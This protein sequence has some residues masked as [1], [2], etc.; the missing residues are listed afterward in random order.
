[1]PRGRTRRQ[2]CRSSQQIPARW[3]DLHLH[4]T[5]S[6]GVYAPAKLIE[7]AATRGLSAV[8][9]TDHDTTAGLPEAAAAARVHGIEFVPGIELSARYGARLIHILGYW[10]NPESL[11]LV[12][13]LADQAARGAQRM[14]RIRSRLRDCGISIEDHDLADAAGSRVGR[15]HVA[16]ILVR[17]GLVRDHDEAFT[18]YLGVGA[19][20]F[21][22][23]EA[24]PA[25]EAI[26]AIRAAGGVACLAHPVW[27]G[28]TSILELETVIRDLMT[29]GLRGLEV[30][31][32]AQSGEWAERCRALAE[33]LG[34]AM[35]GGTDF[36]GFGGCAQR[37]VGFGNPRVAY[38]Y[39]E[40]LNRCRSAAT[41]SP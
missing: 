38:E 19:P 3:V 9:L 21:V 10:I 28:C 12:R 37:G 20:A 41:A 24:L 35:T 26:E 7:L 34:L 18:K 32:P 1:M 40:A 15:P 2:L 31:H 29:A 13:V 30:L 25:A 22:E 16:R 33:K 8:A 27:L 14:Q 39:L 4:S 6:D 17:R 23:H 5:A 36:H 11:P